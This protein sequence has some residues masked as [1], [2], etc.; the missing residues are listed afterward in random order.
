MLYDAFLV[1]LCVCLLSDVIGCS[2]C[3]L[4]DDACWILCVIVLKCLLN[5]FVC[6]VLAYCAMVYCLLLCV[7]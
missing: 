4:C 7:L 3:V 6:F 5:V 2:S 1:C